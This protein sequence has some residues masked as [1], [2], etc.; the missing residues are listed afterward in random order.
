[1]NKL[2]KELAESSGFGEAWFEQSAN[3]APAN[4]KEGM[5][6]NFANAIIQQCIESIETYKIQVGN[7]AAGEMAC[8]WTYDALLSIRDEIKEKFGVE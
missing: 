5:L 8:E 2:I 3:G 4:P 6:E 7:S 1:M